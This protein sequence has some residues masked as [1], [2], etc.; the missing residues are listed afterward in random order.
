MAVT[1]VLATTVMK[2]MAEPVLTLM[3]VPES[4]VMIIQYVVT[5]QE[6]TNAKN[7]SM[8]LSRHLI[9]NKTLCFLAYPS[10]VFQ[11]KCAF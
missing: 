4:H 9:I 6:L 3:S 7:V 2:E 1:T 11:E 10:R 8:F 5:L